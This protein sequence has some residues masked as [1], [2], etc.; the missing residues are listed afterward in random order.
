MDGYTATREM[1]KDER[2]KELPIITMTAHAIAG[3][4]D[5]NLQ[6]GRK[7]HV[8]KPIDPDQLFSTPQKW[9]KPSETRAQVKQTEVPL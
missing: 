5:K 4:E 3:D 7:G 9:I 8:A 6:A 2:F 1:R